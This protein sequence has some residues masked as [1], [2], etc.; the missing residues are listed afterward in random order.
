[1][2]SRL[3]PHSATRQMSFAAT[4]RRRIL[5]RPRRPRPF[6]TSELR[7]LSVA[8]L[9]AASE[10]SSA[11]GPPPVGAAGPV[12]PALA[13]SLKFICSS[14]ELQVGASP[15]TQEKFGLPAMKRT[16][17]RTVLSPSRRTQEIVGKPVTITA[18]A[19]GSAAAPR[20]NA[21]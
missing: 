11:L 13:G 8:S 7:Q 6:G 10:A 9:I 16:V 12:G 5:S 1:M 19:A 17:P 18:G 21:T 3:A 4:L 20:A 2:Q 14:F 15:P